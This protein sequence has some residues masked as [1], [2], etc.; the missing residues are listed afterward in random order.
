MLYASLHDS[1]LHGPEKRF[2]ELE[3]PVLRTFRYFA[4][5]V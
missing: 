1:G 5:T 2:F 4:Y 3:E